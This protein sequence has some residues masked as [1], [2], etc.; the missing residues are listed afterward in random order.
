MGGKEG[1]ESEA[2]GKLRVNDENS[3]LRQ[4]YCVR[5]VKGPVLM[6]LTFWWKDRDDR[7]GGER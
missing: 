6:E 7:M 5:C 2:G 4:S 3:A 1:G